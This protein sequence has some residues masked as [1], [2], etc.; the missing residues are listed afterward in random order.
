MLTEDEARKFAAHWVQAWNSRDVDEI[1]S[2]YGPNVV[3]VSP[4]AVRVLSDPSGT[5]QGEEALRRYFQRGLAAYPHLKF[6]LVDVMRGLS[7]V[8]LYYVNQEG[9]KT[10]EFMEFDESGKV[11]RVVANYGGSSDA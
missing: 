1:M 9:T 4:V 2:H 11:I 7:S 8:V 10:G 3:L 5:V 6:E